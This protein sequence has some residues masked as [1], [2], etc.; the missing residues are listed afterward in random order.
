MGKHE[1][2]RAG[3]VL[4]RMPGVPKSMLALASRECE[5]LEGRVSWGKGLVVGQLVPD[6]VRP[7]RRLARRSADAL[8]GLDELAPAG[9][10]KEP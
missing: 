5:L 10:S 7:A 8:R 2:L 4:I 1:I 9:T 3:R 6:G